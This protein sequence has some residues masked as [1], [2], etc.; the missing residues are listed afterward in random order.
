MPRNLIALL[1]IFLQ[2]VVIDKWYMVASDGELVLMSFTP[3]SNREGR[4]K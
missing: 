1:F 3:G 2:S 4:Y